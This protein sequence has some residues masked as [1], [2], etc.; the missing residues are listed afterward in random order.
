MFKK[1]LIIL[2][3]VALS[4]PIFSQRSIAKESGSIRYSTAMNESLK[5]K[6]EVKVKDLFSDQAL[7]FVSAIDG[8]YPYVLLTKKNDQ[9]VQQNS[10]RG[11]TAS[12]KKLILM[13]PEEKTDPV[14]PLS[15]TQ[16]LLPQDL[17][18]IL[19][20][21]GKRSKTSWIVHALTLY[22]PLYSHWGYRK[23][24]DPDNSPLAA[25]FG[26]G[27]ALLEARATSSIEATSP[28][29]MLLPW[30]YIANASK[31]ISAAEE[32][33]T[34]MEQSDTTELV[35][36]VPKN[37]FRAIQKNLSD[38]P[39]FSVIQTSIFPGDRSTQVIP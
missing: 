33:E 38:N 30:G 25:L 22:L 26:I 20:I 19:S 6:D 15:D 32:I 28:A 27:V 10:R 9:T 29:A 13:T 39:H 8:T 35:V 4:A 23:L 1:V 37:L 7:E 24:Y 12:V 31:T 14:F 5:S 18:P 16:Q 34:H 36:L 17:L 21:E 2:S 3:V 11:Q